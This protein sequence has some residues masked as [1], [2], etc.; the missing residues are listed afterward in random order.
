M[1]VRSVCLAA[2]LAAFGFATVATAQ[3]LPSWAAPSPSDAPA[4][5]MGPGAPP[6]PP[7]P[8]PVPIDGGL[9]LLALAGAGYAARRLRGRREG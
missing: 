7:P 2:A 3:S 8:P 9:S 1:M 5:N 4:E 6:P